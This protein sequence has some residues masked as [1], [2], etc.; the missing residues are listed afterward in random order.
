VIVSETR[1]LFVNFRCFFVCLNAVLK[2]I[3]CLGQNF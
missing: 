3:V 1:P 2:F